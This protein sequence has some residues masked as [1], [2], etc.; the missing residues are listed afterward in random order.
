V[1]I[2]Q[3]RF[4]KEKS[5]N[6]SIN[7]HLLYIGQQ[8]GYMDNTDSPRSTIKGSVAPCHNRVDW[9]NCIYEKKNQNMNRSS[10]LVIWTLDKM[11]DKTIDKTIE[12]TEQY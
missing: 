9:T 6:C 4:L 8:Y 5:S 10:R 2:F 11:I 3:E 7:L 12:N 1:R